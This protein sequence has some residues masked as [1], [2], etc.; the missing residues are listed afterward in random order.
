ME[1]IADHIGTFNSL[2]VAWCADV[3]F[4]QLLPLSA[5]DLLLPL[6]E[7]GVHNVV[8]LRVVLVTVSS[9]DLGIFNVNRGNV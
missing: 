9:V 6:G 4:G 3:R 2:E 5:L 1:T 8:H 7:A